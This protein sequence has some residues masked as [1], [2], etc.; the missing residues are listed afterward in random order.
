MGTVI[1]MFGRFHNCITILEHSSVG[2]RHARHTHCTGSPQKYKDVGV[3]Y[4]VWHAG[5]TVTGMI[6][7]GN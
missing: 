5:V 3:L 2:G 6:I 7:L 1:V 4:T